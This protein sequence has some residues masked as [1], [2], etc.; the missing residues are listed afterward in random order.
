MKTE[1]ESACKRGKE[2]LFAAGSLFLE[3]RK[4]AFLWFIKKFAEIEENPE[5]LSL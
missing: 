2:S 1:F 5:I 4:K 3:K